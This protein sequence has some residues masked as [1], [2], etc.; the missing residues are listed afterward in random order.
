MNAQYPKTY[1]AFSTAAR[2]QR[3]N[4]KHKHLDE[5]HSKLQALQAIQE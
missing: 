2:K 1:T 4:N 5:I 3:H